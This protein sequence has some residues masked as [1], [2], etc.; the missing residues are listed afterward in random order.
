M[1]VIKL[2]VTRPPRVSLSLLLLIPL[3]LFGHITVVVAVAAVVDT[4][5]AGAAVEF[6]PAAA[7][8][9]V[10]HPTADVGV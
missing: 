1:P 2:P 7:I 5:Y 3:P 6:V 9:A 8:V 10:A 4:D